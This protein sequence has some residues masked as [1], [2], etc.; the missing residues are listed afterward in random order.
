MLDMYPKSSTI[1]IIIK[2][3]ITKKTIKKRKNRVRKRRKGKRKK[4]RR[5]STKSKRKRL[6]KVVKKN[7]KKKL[8]KLNNDY[9]IYKYNYEI[10]FDNFSNLFSKMNPGN[11]CGDLEKY[12]SKCVCQTC[13]CHKHKCPPADVR[14][15][16]HSD[17]LSF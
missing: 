15:P 17:Q 16:H 9:L 7:R 6:R 13:T 2:T 14:L 5:R 12:H 10:L 4:S 1:K 11:H 3:H 8:R